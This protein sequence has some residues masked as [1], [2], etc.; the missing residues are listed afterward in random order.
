MLYIL[1]IISVIS[2]LIILGLGISLLKS[3]RAC[4]RNQDDLA[5]A[6]AK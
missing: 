4:R 1:I 2:V 3:K 6:K 5:N